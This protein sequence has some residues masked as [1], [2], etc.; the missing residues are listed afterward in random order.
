M[1]FGDRL[2]HTLLSPNQ[3]RSAGH[4]VNECPKQFD[5]RSGHNISNACDLD[6]SLKLSGIISYGPMRQPTTKELTKCPRIEMTS[7]AEWRW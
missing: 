2:P 5:S 7:E 3:I 1:H 6:L 4:Q